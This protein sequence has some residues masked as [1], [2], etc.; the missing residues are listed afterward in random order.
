MADKKDRVEKFKSYVEAL[1]KQ[2]LGWCEKQ[3]TNAPTRFWSGG[4]QAR[5]GAALAAC[6][7]PACIRMPSTQAPVLTH[8]PSSHLIRR[9]CRTT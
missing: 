7:A 2:F 6:A 3:S 1:N 8:G 5:W 9:L 4:L